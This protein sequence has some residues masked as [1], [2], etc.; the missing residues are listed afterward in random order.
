MVR[1]NL[2]NEKCVGIEDKSASCPFLINIRLAL[3]TGE[4]PLGR[5]EVL[6]AEAVLVF[7]PK[8]SLT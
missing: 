7:M 8:P 1:R 2:K 6:G 5:A 3:S 4:F